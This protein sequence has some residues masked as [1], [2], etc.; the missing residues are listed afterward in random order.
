MKQKSYTLPLP[1]PIFVNDR[2]TLMRYLCKIFTL[3]TH[4][5]FK[6]L[7]FFIRKI[8][9][10]WKKTIDFWLFLKQID[11]KILTKAG[12][13]CLPKEG[14]GPEVLLANTKD[15][16]TEGK[17]FIFNGHFDSWNTSPKVKCSRCNDFKNFQIFQN[18]TV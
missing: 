3:W 14:C 6:T 12:C 15:C 11:E 8:K 13:K 7:H 1:L 18:I 2:P 17:N 5:T 10:F 9:A 4:G 16:S